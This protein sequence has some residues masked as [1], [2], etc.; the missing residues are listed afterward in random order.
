MRSP[1]VFSDGNGSPS[2]LLTTE[3]VFTTPDRLALMHKNDS[4]YALARRQR[5]VPVARYRINLYGPRLGFA[6]ARSKIL[7]PHV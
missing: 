7:W 2:F 3:I 1:S 4:A 5:R 6:I